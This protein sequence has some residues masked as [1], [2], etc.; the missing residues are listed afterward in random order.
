MHRVVPLKFVV[1]TL[2]FGLT[3]FFVGQAR[4]SSR[5]VILETRAHPVPKGLI[6]ALRIQLAG[7]AEVSEVTLPSAAVRLGEAERERRE[8]TWLLWV[9]ESGG[10]PVVR[11]L[12]GSSDSEPVTLSPAL[13]DSPELERI[14]ALKVGL[15]LERPSPRP[16]P[17]TRRTILGA[18]AELRLSAS[19]GG[20]PRLW[21]PSVGF[22][23]GPRWARSNWLFEAH[24]SFALRAELDARSRVGQT[25]VSATYLGAGARVLRRWSR[26]AAGPFVEVGLETLRARGIAKD[27][28]RGAAELTAPT[29]TL[30]LQ[31]RFRAHENLELC[32]SGSGELWLTRERLELL[33]TPTVD[34]GRIR[35]SLGI[36]A[37][38]LFR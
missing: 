3:L 17:E 21:L 36:S 35:A 24:G 27:K 31:I 13:S 37:I 14:V 30:G 2:M 19:N 23:A 15:L 11:V 16:E 25:D 20:A 28:R 9:E 26:L 8:G 7:S 38:F 22:A 4:A 18:F 6:E 32:A 10:E 1:A 29:T 34:S 12:G 33:G 5:L